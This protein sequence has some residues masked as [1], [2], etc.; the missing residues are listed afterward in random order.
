[1]KLS[2]QPLA[3]CWHSNILVEYFVYK[4]LELTNIISKYV[5]L[6]PLLADPLFLIGWKKYCHSYIEKV[7]LL[8]GIILKIL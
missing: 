3:D 5:V 7:E 2:E 1:M 6:M 8:E 4:I